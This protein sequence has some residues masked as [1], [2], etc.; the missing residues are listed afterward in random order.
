MSLDASYV[1]PQGICL[2]SGVRSAADRSLQLA[3][4]TGGW[5]S[6]SA[7]VEHLGNVLCVYMWIGALFRSYRGHLLSA[8]AT[9]REEK[10]RM[11]E[12]VALTCSHRWLLLATGRAVAVVYCSSVRRWSCL[13]Q[14][15]AVRIRRSQLPPTGQPS[16]VS[17]TRKRATPI[18]P[19]S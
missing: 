9:R 7:R 15:Y 5:C 18:E 2:A 16:L 8:W 1:R 3:T 12:L 13:P 6:T 11:R 14:L 19:A 17:G 10:R 4:A